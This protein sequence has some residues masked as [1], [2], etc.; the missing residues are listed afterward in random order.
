YYEA[1]ADRGYGYGPAFRG[2]RA[3]WRRGDEVF[4]EVALPADA[5]A[6][7][8]A[9]GIHPALLDAALHVAGLAGGDGAKE[10]SDARLPFTWNGVSLRAAG[11]SSL[12]VRL[13]QDP[14]SGRLSL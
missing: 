9:F 8:A 6:E 10:P 14:A 5:A 1:L 11:A 3:A 2:L 12:R 7:A 13:S 4:A